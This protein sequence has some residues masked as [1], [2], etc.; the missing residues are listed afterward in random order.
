M[1]FSKLNV[2]IKF[3][4]IILIIFAL[5]QIHLELKVLLFS[6]CRLLIS[7]IRIFGRFFVQPGKTSSVFLSSEFSAEWIF[8]P[9]PASSTWPKAPLANR[10]LTFISFISD[11]SEDHSIS[12]FVNNPQ[13]I[14][15]NKVGFRVYLYQ[16]FKLEHIKL[17]LQRWFGWWDFTQWLIFGSINIQKL[18]W[19]QENVQFRMRWILY[20][21]GFS[22][23]RQQTR[24]SAR[25]Y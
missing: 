5:W 18:L 13:I 19:W 23:I 4:K 10:L 17:N 14:A 7:F 6:L 22:S 24:L 3:W 21:S 11:T 2:K 12:G 20:S 16:N 8:W 1:T 15:Q 25:F 9:F